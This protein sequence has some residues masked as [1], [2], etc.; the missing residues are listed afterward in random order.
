VNNKEHQ[1][2]C[3]QRSVF[4]RLL[5][6]CGVGL[7]VRGVSVSQCGREQS[8]SSSPPPLSFPLF[9]GVTGACL[10]LVCEGSWLDCSA[11]PAMGVL[12]S[13]GVVCQ[14]WKPLNIPGTQP[15]LSDAVVNLCQ[16]SF[17]VTFKPPYAYYLF[18]ILID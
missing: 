2:T 4:K 18:I 16:H 5:N 7:A 9:F 11:V 3:G 6:S 13:L 8:S 12:F 1:Q 10:S 14:K 17:D 15:P